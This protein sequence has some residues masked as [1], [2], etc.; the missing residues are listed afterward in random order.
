MGAG[1]AYNI[2]KHML[3]NQEDL[4][5][6]QD[7]YD[8]VQEWKN[9]PLEDQLRAMEDSDLFF[10][11]GEDVLE[12]MD[13]EEIEEN[14]K[15]FHSLD[16]EKWMEGYYADGYEFGEGIRDL[17]EQLIECA[18]EAAESLDFTEDFGAY[19]D[20]EREGDIVVMGDGACDIEGFS[21][22]RFKAGLL[23]DQYNNGVVVFMQDAQGE[24]YI[25]DIDDED[26]LNIVTADFAPNMDFQTLMNI[27]GSLHADTVDPIL[28]EMD[29]NMDDNELQV[30]LGDKVDVFREYVVSISNEGPHTKDDDL[31]NWTGLGREEQSTE[32]RY[33][34]NLFQNDRKVE[35]R[36]LLAKEIVERL[37]AAKQQVSD[38][39]EQFADKTMDGV[40]N[41]FKDKTFRFATS[42]WTS[43][44]YEKGKVMFSGPV[45]SPEPDMAPSP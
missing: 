38:L 5:S 8:F 28:L 13:L 27:K 7:H 36:E 25:R 17:K 30:V 22:V 24:N 33:E 1:H 39:F 15:T 14:G 12:Q 4:T 16:V 2:D 3:F 19:M 6:Y 41:R 18:T 10:P 21:E 32:D 42:A 44:P 40:I 11:E 20:E 35:I 43:A 34:N 9:K 31:A 29:E 23:S 26:L 45:K 37:D